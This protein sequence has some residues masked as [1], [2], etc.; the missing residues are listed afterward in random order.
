[1]DA[2][3]GSPPFSFSAS[4]G[5]SPR[6]G[7]TYRNVGRGFCFSRAGVVRAS[8]ATTTSRALFA[9]DDVLGFVP[10]ACRYRAVAGGNRAETA[11]RC[12]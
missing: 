8:F 2:F 11:A 10:S 4:G 3:S 12:A 6:L 7:T 9:T 5:T 1:M